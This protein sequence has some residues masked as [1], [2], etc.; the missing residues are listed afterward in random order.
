MGQDPNFKFTL[1]RSIYKT[2]LRFSAERHGKSCT[3]TPLAPLFLSAE[4][5][6]NNVAVLK[7]RETPDVDESSASPSSYVIYKAIG[8]G[9][10]DNG[11]QVNGTSAKVKITVKKK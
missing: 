10:F 4:V 8:N 11:T 5:G 1:A 9:G 3:V 7:W 2:L 6:E